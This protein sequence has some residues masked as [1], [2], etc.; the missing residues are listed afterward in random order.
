MPMDMV[1]CIEGEASTRDVRINGKLLDPRVSQKV[2][3]HSP[4]GFNWGYNGSGPAQL[5]LG[6]LIHVLGDVNWAQTLYQ[7]F[8]REVVS[9][10]R[11]NQN[12]EVYFDVLA[13]AKEKTN[14]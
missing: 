10:W 2:R 14:V 1:V 12:F 8:K 6:I 11:Q 7:D 13:W 3:D 4:D 5:A 9:R